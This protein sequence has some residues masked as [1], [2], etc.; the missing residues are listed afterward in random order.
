MGEQTKKFLFVLDLVLLHFHFD[1]HC[2]EL[3]LTFL[4]IIVVTKTEEWTRTYHDDGSDD[5]SEGGPHD[6]A[7]CSD[8]ELHLPRVWIM[9][10][11]RDN[12]QLRVGDKD[13]RKKQSDQLN[14]DM[15]MVNGLCMSMKCR[16]FFITWRKISSLQNLLPDW[17]PC[18]RSSR[19]RWSLLLRVIRWSS[20]S[21][22]GR[23]EWTEAEAACEQSA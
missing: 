8:E 2:A 12:I 21:S 19:T 15:L 22:P 16:T 17:R 7:T 6:I 9:R 11:I 13:L 10:R 5:Q 18:S 3:W 4:T 20:G 1:Q 14:L 23:N